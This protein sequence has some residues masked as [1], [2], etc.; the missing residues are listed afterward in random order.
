VTNSSI[1][2]WQKTTNQK[3]NENNETLE[4]AQWVCI[5]GNF[6]NHIGWLH[7]LRRTD[8]LSGSTTATATASGCGNATTGTGCRAD[9][10]TSPG[11]GSG[12]SH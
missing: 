7:N 6:H 5:G 10:T 2:Q 9:T 1:E 8:G 11:G 4:R 3:L 12:N